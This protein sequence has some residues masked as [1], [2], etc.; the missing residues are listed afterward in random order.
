[1]ICGSL[2]YAGCANHHAFK[3]KKLW[4]DLGH[5]D[6]AGLRELVTVGDVV[7]LALDDGIGLLPLD[8]IIING[9]LDQRIGMGIARP[10]ARTEVQVTHHHARLLVGRLAGDLLEQFLRELR[11]CGIE[12]H[13]EVV[14]DTRRGLALEQRPQLGD[15]ALRQLRNL[16][17]EL[18]VELL[19]L[20]LLGALAL[21]TLLV[22]TAVKPRVDDHAVQR[23]LRLERSVLH[24]AGL[25]AEDGAQQFLLGRGVALALGG[26][27]TDQDVARMYV[28]TDADDTVRIEIFGG[29]LAYVRNIRGQFLDTALG[30]AHLHDILVDVHRREDILTLDTL[31]DHDGILEVVTLPG[32]ERHFQVAAQGQLAVL[33]RVTLG[34]D[35]PLHDLVA[36]QYGGL[37]RDGGILGERGGW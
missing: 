35:L 15:Q 25:V 26:D 4:V 3:K 16:G 8:G 37:E 7:L 20:R 10:L 27:F 31:R 11:A 13:A 34:Q 19:E 14:G 32:H 12:F 22:R 23:R 2:W 18:L 6:N 36:R 17:C 33:R 1:M 29:V 28:G 9:S 24:V 5:L 21:L 30:V